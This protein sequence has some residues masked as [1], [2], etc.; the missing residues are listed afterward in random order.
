M[1]GHCGA[2]STST[3]C[4]RPISYA[5]YK[6]TTKFLRSSQ[7]L[8]VLSLTV[9]HDCK[10]VGS[11]SDWGPS[12]TAMWTPAPWRAKKAQCSATFFSLV[13]GNFISRACKCDDFGTRRM[14]E[15]V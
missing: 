6:C 1:G 2:R 8:R 15:H 11:V 12:C 14:P 9:H 10:Y 5:P 3:S 4:P 7:F 13:A